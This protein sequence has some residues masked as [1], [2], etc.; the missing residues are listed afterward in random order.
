MHISRKKIPETYISLLCVYA[1][2]WLTISYHDRVLQCSS[3]HLFQ[4]VHGYSKDSG[5]NGERLHWQGFRSVMSG[6]LNLV[7][8]LSVYST[9]NIALRMIFL[10][11]IY[12]FTVPHFI[13]RALFGGVFDFCSLSCFPFKSKFSSVYFVWDVFLHQQG[14]LSLLLNQKY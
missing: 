8:C 7:Y 14:H 11:G 12:I 2:V 5:T 6:F 4:C 3:R 1:C 10:H 9:W 13:L